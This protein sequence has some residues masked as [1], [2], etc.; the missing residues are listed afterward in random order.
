MPFGEGMLLKK[1]EAITTTYINRY[2][3]TEIAP[4]FIVNKNLRIGA[5]Y[6]YSVGLDEGAIKSSQYGAINA[7][8][9]NIKLS[10]TFLLG[11]NPQ[12]YYLN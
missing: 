7:S 10:E 3:V 11:I 4:Y 6:F 8:I 5:Y 12:F 2:F 9:S 1:H